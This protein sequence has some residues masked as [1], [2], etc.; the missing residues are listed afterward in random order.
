[1]QGTLAAGAGTSTLAGRASGSGTVAIDPHATLQATG[2]I[3]ATHLKFVAGGHETLVLTKPAAM[4]A[5]ISGFAAS[6][7]IDLKNLV[8]KSLS[9]S[10]STLTVSGTTGT[11]ATLKFAGPY[12]KANFVRSSDSHGGT[13]ITFKA[14]AVASRDLISNAISGG[15]ENAPFALLQG[16]HDGGWLDLGHVVSGSPHG[17]F[18]WHSPGAG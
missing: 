10:S 2:G 14:T 8:V 12:T 6:D 17:H 13:D 16:Q 18:L 15:P 5:T 1:V 3:A 4:A 11:I 7:T 9:F